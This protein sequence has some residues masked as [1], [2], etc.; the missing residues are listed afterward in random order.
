[1]RTRQASGAWPARRVAG[2]EP[3]SSRPGSEKSRGSQ[4][5]II[6]SGP[7][8]AISTPRRSLR[9]R[10]TYTAIATP[11]SQA[12]GMEVHSIPVSNATSAGAR[13]PSAPLIVA[14]RQRLAAIPSNGRTMP[15]TD[16]SSDP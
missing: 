2:S 13:R 3:V 1:M 16:M 7:S 12:Q 15:S 6:A 10:P 4:P 9:G 11:S 8:T 5:A 14:L